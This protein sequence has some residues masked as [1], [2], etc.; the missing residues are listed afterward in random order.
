MR[1]IFFNSAIVFLITIPG[2]VLISTLIVKSFI[3]NKFCVLSIIFVV[4]VLLY[5]GYSLVVCHMKIREVYLDYV[6]FIILNTLIF[7]SLGLLLSSFLE[8]KIRMNKNKM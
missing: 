2:I 7:G 6:G 4:Q 1:E 5:Y 8:K 3:K